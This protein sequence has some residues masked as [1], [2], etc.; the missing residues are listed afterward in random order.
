MCGYSRH[1]KPVSYKYSTS[2]PQSSW[3]S[4]YAHVHSLSTSPSALRNRALFGCRHECIQRPSILQVQN[5]FPEVI[6]HFC[7]VSDLREICR[8]SSGIFRNMTNENM[9]ATRILLS[10]FHNT[11]KL[12]NSE[13]GFMEFCTEIQHKCVHNS[14]VKVFTCQIINVV[15]VAVSQLRNRANVTSVQVRQLSRT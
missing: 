9:A 12:R 2:N 14:C 6:L 8:L 4:E 10:V 7:M 15:F 11:N 13:G 3:P 1:C 5:I